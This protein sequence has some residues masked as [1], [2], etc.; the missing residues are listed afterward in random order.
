MDRKKLNLKQILLL[1]TGMIIIAIFGFIYY[2]RQHIHLKN[3]GI[4]T[5]EVGTKLDFQAKD[6]F[7][8]NFFTSAEREKINQKI[9]VNFQDLT[10]L[11]QQKEFINIG[12][13][14]GAITYQ[15]MCIRDR[16]YAFY[17]ISLYAFTSYNYPY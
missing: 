14:Q 8:L 11:D 5:L 1:V 13:Y 4:Y 16:Y 6:Y 2:Q 15:K 12:K 9:K 7:D 17:S 3:Q 10:Y